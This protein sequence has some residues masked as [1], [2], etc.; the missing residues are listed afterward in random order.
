MSRF[1]LRIPLMTAATAC[2][3]TLAAATPPPESPFAI[4]QPPFFGQVRTRTEFDHKAMTDTSLNKSLLSTQL[5][6]RLGFLAS[7]S[8]KVEIKVEIQDTR[9]MGTEPSSATTAVGTAAHTASTGNRSGVDL[10]QGYVA[11]QEGPVKV[12]VGRQKM[13]LG[14][15]RYMSTLEWSPTSR[16]FDG[17][18]AN[19]SVGGGDLT[20]L[21]FLVKD[22]ASSTATTPSTVAATDDRLILS[23]LHYNIKLGQNLTAEASAFYDKST[24]RNVYSG[25]TLRRYDLVYLGQRTAGQFGLLTF[26]EELLWQAGKAENAAGRSLTSA[27]YQV[28]LRAGIALPKV[29][30][31]IGIDLMSG[32]ND[33]TD[34]KTTLYRANYYFAHAYF[35]WMDYFI[36]NPKY[37]VIDYRADVDAMLWQG[38]TQ[39]ISLKAQY[40]YFTPQNA[41]SAD[42]AMYGQEID[43]EVHF[44]LYPKSNIVLG[45]GAF[46]PGGSAYKLGAAKIA[47]ATAKDETGFFV[48]FMP[49]FNF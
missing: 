31:N 24:L 19:W 43:A 10:L 28:A 41:P 46:I 48:Y 5:R 22:T 14:A 8:E 17:V 16:A 13:T 39:A 44:A 3:A 7:P 1:L 21:V 33:A 2:L 20:G 15:G 6:T 37:G 11:I 30:A 26:E 9:V 38:E 36:A 25:D 4:P 45:A 34:D 35:G 32:D 29:K 40:H 23:G 47:N 49:V 27:A 12:A 42:D 18:S